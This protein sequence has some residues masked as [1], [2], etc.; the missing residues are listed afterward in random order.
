[1]FGGN[2]LRPNTVYRAENPIYTRRK[3]YSEYEKNVPAC[4]VDHKFK[5]ALVSRWVNCR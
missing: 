3:C 1:M 4:A 2:R 5:P